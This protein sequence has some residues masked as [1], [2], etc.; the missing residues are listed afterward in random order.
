MSTLAPIPAGLAKVIGE[1]LDVALLPPFLR[2]LLT[3]DGTVTKSLEAFFWETI[4]VRSLGQDYRSLDEAEPSLDKPAGTTVLL[5]RVRLVGVTTGTCYA[6]AESVICTG[7]LP[8]GVRAGLEEGRLGIGEILRDCG[9][10]TYR[11]LV[12]FGRCSLDASGD[13]VTAETQESEGIWRRYQICI[14]GKPFMLIKEFF[15]LAVFSKSP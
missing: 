11:R 9:L 3:T 14:G 6:H 13:P 15:P 4:A 8:Y 1:A 12:D 2:V 5:R 7:E 10:E